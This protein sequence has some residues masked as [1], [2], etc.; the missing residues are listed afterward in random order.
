MVFYRPGVGYLGDFR[1]DARRWEREAERARECRESPACQFMRE[2]NPGHFQ[3]CYGAY[4]HFHHQGLVQVDFDDIEG[5][6]KKPYGYNVL[7]RLMFVLP[8]YRGRGVG[9]EM[10]Y[11]LTKAAEETG[12]TITA[13]CVPVEWSFGSL[14]DIRGSPPKERTPEEQ[15]KWVAQCFDEF[16]T[17]ME[18]LDLTKKE[19]KDKQRRQRQRFLDAGFKRCLLGKNISKKNRQKLSHWTMIYIPQTCPI[20]QREFLEPRLRD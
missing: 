1:A 10:L 2:I 17:S 14:E 5:G 6:P 9:S 20:E 13:V 15:C 7:L 4:E 16:S 12:C 19:N 3:Q 18:Y 8:Q 11:Y